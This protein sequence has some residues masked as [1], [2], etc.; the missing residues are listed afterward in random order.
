MRIHWRDTN[1]SVGKW[2]KALGT[3]LG[4]FLLVYLF[5]KPVVQTYFLL[6]APRRRWDL[7]A[8]AAGRPVER[9]SF[10][11]T[12]GIDLVGWF[13]PGDGS[14]ATIVISHGSHANG[15]IT[16]PGAAFLNDAGYSILVYDNRGHGY[17]GGKATTMGPREVDDLRGAVA[18]LQSR[19][20]VDA[21]RIGAMG[22]SMGSAVT[23][24]AAAVEPAIKAA[25]AEAV[26]ADMRELWDRFGYTGIRGTPIHWTWGPLLRLT[27][28]MWTGE[29]VGDFRPEALI[30]QIS[31]RPIF[32]IHS[33][34]DNGACTVSDAR[35]L[36]AAANEP[37][38]LWIVPGAGHCSAHYYQT[39]EYERRILA[40]FDQA[41]RAE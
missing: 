7:T 30:G 38:E 25:V 3:V 33:E 23:I 34:Y 13:V 17:S 11:A 1:M 15:P 5:A 20:D 37:K 22:C 24:G 21:E 8:E 40:F 35:R 18:Y 2:L 28:R 39:E 19:P 9:V 16:Y 31:P 6:R 41:L 27:A 4:T 29:K 10:Q 14:G 26:Y 12:D 32:I 36:Y